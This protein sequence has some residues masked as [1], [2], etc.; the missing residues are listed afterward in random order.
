MTT[1][2]QQAWPTERMRVLR[3]LA[4]AVSLT[5]TARMTRAGSAEYAMAVPEAT[6]VAPATKRLCTPGSAA[7]GVRLSGAMV[8]TY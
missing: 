8:Q 5:G 3:P 2:L 7:F 4:A 1:A 6:T